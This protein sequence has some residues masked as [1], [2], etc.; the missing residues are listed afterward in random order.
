MN[1][2][3]FEVTR[4]FPRLPNRLGLIGVA[5]PMQ[6]ALAIFG[7]QVRNCSAEATAAEHSNGVLISHNVSVVSHLTWRIARIIRC[8]HRAASF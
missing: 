6:D 1:L 2:D 7:K 5:H 3:A 8:S 4:I